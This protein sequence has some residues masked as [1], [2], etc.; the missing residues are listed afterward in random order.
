MIHSWTL[1]ILTSCHAMLSRP[2]CPSAD[3]WTLPTEAVLGKKVCFVSLHAPIQCQ[4]NTLM[5]PWC[6]FH[7]GLRKTPSVFVEGATSIQL[8]FQKIFQQ[9]NRRKKLSKYRW[10]LIPTSVLDSFLTTF[11]PNLVSTDSSFPV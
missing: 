4:C 11:A 2:S 1:C 10:Y 6:G 9:R 3:T 5:Y 8:I 7:N